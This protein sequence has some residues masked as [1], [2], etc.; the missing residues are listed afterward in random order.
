[1]LLHNY[2][3]ICLLDTL[4]LL[5][6]YIYG[7]MLKFQ[8]VSQVLQSCYGKLQNNSVHNMDIQVTATVNINKICSRVGSLHVL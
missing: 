1:M 5:L 4:C 8:L 7:Y 2:K 3:L 6:Y